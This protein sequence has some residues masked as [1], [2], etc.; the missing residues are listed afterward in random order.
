MLKETLLG[1]KVPPLPWTL[2]L[3]WDGVNPSLS[4]EQ[5]GRRGG[6]T[7]LHISRGA[8]ESRLLSTMAK[9]TLWN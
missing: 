3:P 4:K 8:G 7:G 5:A 6:S 2:G 9:T 1:V